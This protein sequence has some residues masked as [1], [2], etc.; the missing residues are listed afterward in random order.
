MYD[1][2]GIYIIYIRSVTFTRREQAGNLTHKVFSAFH[3][4]SALAG[5]GKAEQGS[6]AESHAS[7]SR[8]HR[9]T[10]VTETYHGQ[11]QQPTYSSSKSKRH[12]PHT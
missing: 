11:G 5:R 12:W 2:P 9:G 6:G 8:G 1:I 7:L 10:S 3:I 4:L